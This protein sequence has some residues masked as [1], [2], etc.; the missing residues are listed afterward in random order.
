[1]PLPKSVG[2]A[3]TFGLH[4]LGTVDELFDG[5][6]FVLHVFYKVSIYKHKLP[7]VNAT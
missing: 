5:V 3:E 2:T 7:D 6:K 4:E 1:M